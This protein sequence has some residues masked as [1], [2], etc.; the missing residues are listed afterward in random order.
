MAADRF[1][2]TNVISTRLSLEAAV[3]EVAEG[4]RQSLST[5]PDMAVVTISSAYASEY[6]RLVP[7]LL[8][9]LPCRELIGCGGGGIIGTNSQQE[10]CEMESTPALSVSAACLPEVEIDPFHISAE[11]LPDLDGPVD[12]WVDLVGV[13]PDRQPHFVLLADPFS[14]KI[15]DLL[16]GLDFA[17]PQATKV[18]GLASTGAMGTPSGLFYHSERQP[19]SPL[20]QSG[21]VGFALSGNIT[22]ESI[23]AQGCRPIGPLLQ[24]AEGERNIISA[25]TTGPERDPQPPLE[26]LRETVNS[27]SE[28]DRELAETSL[29]VGLAMDGFKLELHQ[30]DFL[31]RNLMGVDPRS[32]AMAI[33]DRVRPGQRFQFH[34]RDA[35]T[36]ADDLDLLLRNYTKDCG[37][38]QAA[39]ALLFSCLGRG[40]GLYGKPNFDTQ[41]FQRHLGQTVPVGGFF[42][43][44]EIGPV[45]GQTFLHGYTSVFGIFRPRSPRSALT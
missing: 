44:G 16:A 15:N 3:R 12:A 36:S 9:Q 35:N 22:V 20:Y 7:L 18:G 23:V 14:A 37:Q 6:S 42:C 5:S 4:I 1:Q 28:A 10:A 40:E 32:G 2:W 21:T 39:G 29:F 30:G 8:E 34:L 24:I 11:S 13:A 25:A 45:A 33:G 26:L 43:N 19:R 17:Y 41:L 38:P 31:I 27:L